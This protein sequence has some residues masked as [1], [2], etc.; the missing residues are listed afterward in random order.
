MVRGLYDTSWHMA[1]GHVRHV[2]GLVNIMMQ[3]RTSSVTGFNDVYLVVFLVYKSSFTPPHVR[4]SGAQ[5]G[6][7]QNQPRMCRLSA[8]PT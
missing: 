6:V 8:S 7:G 2:E 4:I 5:R 1:G 3:R